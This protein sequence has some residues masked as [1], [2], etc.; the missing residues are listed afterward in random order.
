MTHIGELQTATEW[1][2]SANGQVNINNR[3]SISAAS[4]PLF[5]DFCPDLQQNFCTVTAETE[6][7]SIYVPLILN[8]KLDRD[9]VCNS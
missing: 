1:G 5:S 7:S 2:T 9:I 4:V 6:Q 8:T 3:S